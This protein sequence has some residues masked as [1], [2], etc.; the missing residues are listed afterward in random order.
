M[1]RLALLFGCT[2]ARLLPEGPLNMEQLMALND[3]RNGVGLEVFLNGNKGAQEHLPLIMEMIK[4]NRKYEE[5]VDASGITGQVK[6][7]V[8]PSDKYSNLI[9]SKVDMAF[10]DP[11]AQ[12]SARSAHL[13]QF[14]EEAANAEKAAKL[15]LENP[16]FAGQKIDPYILAQAFGADESFLPPP[17]VS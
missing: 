3:N 17:P 4:S 8:S 2:A 6:D 11:P 12:P 5:E 1:V 16:A 14:E 9:H 15:I 13:E 7:N 10:M